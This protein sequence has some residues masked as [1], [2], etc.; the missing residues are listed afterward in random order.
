MLLKYINFKFLLL[1]LEGPW[2]SWDSWDGLVKPATIRIKS[3]TLPTPQLW[4]IEA[5]PLWKWDLDSQSLWEKLVGEPTGETQSSL[6]RLKSCIIQLDSTYNDGRDVTPYVKAN[7]C[8]GSFLSSLNTQIWDENS[9]ISI[10]NIWS[11]LMKNPKIGLAL[12]NIYWEIPR[13]LDEMYKSDMEMIKRYSQP[14]EALYSAELEN[15]SP[16]ESV[17]RISE[18]KSNPLNWIA[19]KLIE[20]PKLFRAYHL[21]QI[22]NRNPLLKPALTALGAL[23]N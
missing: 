4:D 19:I 17:S 10:E 16:Y 8:L 3:G 20:D 21:Y 23:S 12:F 11:Y 7:S 15:E 9:E 6:D 13:D 1:K 18:D 5:W 2:E 14:F 22:F